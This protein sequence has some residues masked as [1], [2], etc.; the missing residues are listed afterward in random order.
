[1]MHKLFLALFLLLAVNTAC[2]AAAP[3]TGVP[4]LR[5]VAISGESAPG[6][7]RTFLNFS[8]PVINNSGQTAFIGT[9]NCCSIPG[10]V[11]S[12]GT[13]TL[14]LVGL[15][16]SPAVVGG[17]QNYTSFYNAQLDDLGR[18]TVVANINGAPAD[19]QGVFT[20]LDSSNVT[21]IAASGQ[22]IVGSSPSASYFNVG[23]VS[24]GSNGTIAANVQVQGTSNASLL[25]GSDGASPGHKILQKGDP[26]PF[27]G[28]GVTF[29][30]E[31]G[32][33]FD[34]PTVNSLG[35]LGLRAAFSTDGFFDYHLIFVDSN[36]QVESVVD[37]GDA[38]PGFGGGVTFGAISA[39]AINDLGDFAYGAEI[40]PVGFAS[41]AGVWMSKRG[42]LPQLIA[43]E[44]TEPPGMPGY[45]FSNV[46]FN[47]FGDLADNF[48]RISDQ[49]DVVF[50]AELSGGFV[51]AAE[52]VWIG[53]SSSDLHRILLEG[54]EV[55]GRSGVTFQSE[56]SSSGDLVSQLTVNKNSQ[57]AFQAYIAGIGPGLRR[58]LFATDIFGD[59]HTIVLYGDLIEVSPGIFRQ[60]DD[61]DFDGGRFYSGSGLSDLGEVA[62]RVQFSDGSAGVFVS[63]AV[64]IPE[65]ASLFWAVT[66]AIVSMAAFRRQK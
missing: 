50:R 42:Q 21:R 41:P 34:E 47:P 38:A 17:S 9:L 22:P 28:S 26:V 63:T 65:P 46:L 6:A 43:L 56:A 66:I 15:I 13:G 23:A 64:A 24:V 4:S 40:G 52:S 37:S 3:P 11:W 61:L 12:T 44:Q 49:Q 19:F 45:E 62:F 31:N 18:T 33:S 8:A 39:P 5:K 59:L 54:E 27:A 14:K 55:P 2:L 16:N 30:F 29:G 10:G 32:D 48:V 35:Q 57:V 7:G 53:S 58:G 25:W 60:V 20:G 36:G 51:L 1:M